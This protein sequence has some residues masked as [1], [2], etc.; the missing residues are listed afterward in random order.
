MPPLDLFIASA[1]RPC[2]SMLV[3][4]VTTGTADDYDDGGGFGGGDGSFACDVRI[5]APGGYMSMTICGA[6]DKRACQLQL[7]NNKIND[8]SD[9]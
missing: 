2:T 9:W 5:G 7:Q 4:F 8:C 6:V 3:V 1:S